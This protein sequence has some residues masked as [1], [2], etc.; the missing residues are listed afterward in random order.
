MELSELF[1]VAVLLILLCLAYSPLFILVFK[2]LSSIFKPIVAWFKRLNVQ[3]VKEE[4][5]GQSEYERELKRLSDESVEK[6]KEGRKQKIQDMLMDDSLGKLNK[7]VDVIHRASEE[8]LENRWASH[9]TVRDMMGEG[10]SMK[11]IIQGKRE[12]DKYLLMEVSIKHGIDVTLLKRIVEN[13]ED[14][15]RDER[16][17]GD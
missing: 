3:Q 6:R 7:T 12:A 17:G 14:L 1:F 11:K 9:A 2:I 4:E 13:L 5:A 8:V 15:E 16:D 10:I